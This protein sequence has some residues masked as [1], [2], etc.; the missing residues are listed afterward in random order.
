MIRAFQKL[1]VENNNNKNY[2]L[3]KYFYNNKKNPAGC[4]TSKN[5]FI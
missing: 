4:F 3:T 5:G 2:R 1:Q